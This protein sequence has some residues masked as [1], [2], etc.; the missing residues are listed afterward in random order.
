MLS[1]LERIF[2]ISTLCGISFQRTWE[3]S[4]NS[5]VKNMS[6]FFF[7]FTILHL[8]GLSAVQYLM[9]LSFG[10]SVFFV[11]FGNNIVKMIIT[12]M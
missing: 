12:K 8:L 6:I 4:K 11:L 1:T 2:E 9:K 7:F 3:S 10:A 5:D